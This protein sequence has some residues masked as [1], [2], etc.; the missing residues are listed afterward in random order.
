MAGCLQSDETYWPVVLLTAPVQ[1]GVETVARY[2]DETTRHA[3][4]GAPFVAVL[5]LTHSALLPAQARSRLAAHRRWLF[6]RGTPLIAEAL[7]IRSRAQREFF[8]IPSDGNA[9]PPQRFFATR[10]DAVAFAIAE[11]QLRD[12]P[13]ENSP[14]STSSVILRPRK[15][16]P[17]GVSYSTLDAAVRIPGIAGKR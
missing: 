10:D 8:A 2:V 6:S 13:L 14:T 4:R 12:I 15:V 17:S 7:V 1:W 9:T 5:D 11:L 16:H 3:E